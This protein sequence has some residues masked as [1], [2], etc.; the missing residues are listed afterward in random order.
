MAQVALNGNIRLVRDVDTEQVIAWKNGVFNFTGSDIETTM[1]QIARWYDVEV[2]Y[3]RHI[4]EH[5]NGS[6]PRNAS[7]EKV[8]QLL[9]YTGV[10]RFK[11]QGRKIFVRS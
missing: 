11:I 10:V 6:I 9:Q 3:E 4:P 5:F 7:I 2:K 1:R 8:L